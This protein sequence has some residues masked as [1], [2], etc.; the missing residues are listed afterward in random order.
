MLSD[1][2]DSRTPKAYRKEAYL[3][4]SNTHKEGVELKQYILD[5]CRNRN[6]KIGEI[7]QGRVIRAVGDLYAADA[8]YHKSCRCTFLSARNINYSSRDRS[9]QEIDQPFINICM[10]MKET[11]TKLWSS[12]ELFSL[13]VEEGGERWCRKSLF[14][15]I[16]EHFGDSIVVL[17]SPGFANIIGFKSQMTKSFHL[18]QATDDNLDYCIERVA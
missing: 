18:M 12:V 9:Q 11:E 6:D 8:R 10:K 16:K 3:I 7:V 1:E 14:T 17:S 4:R 13:Y 5:V 15:K 2:Y